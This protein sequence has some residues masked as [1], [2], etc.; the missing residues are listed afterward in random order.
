MSTYS[1]PFTVF[2]PTF[3]VPTLSP[4]LMTFLFSLCLQTCFPLLLLLR[5]TVVPFPPSPFSGIATMVGI[6]NPVPKVQGVERKKN[7]YEAGF[8]SSFRLLLGEG[9]YRVVCRRP[10]GAGVIALSGSRNASWQPERE[11]LRDGEAAC[12]GLPNFKIFIE[13]VIE[14]FPW[15]LSC[16]Y[17]A[18]FGNARQQAF[19]PER[20]THHRNRHLSDTAAAKNTAPGESLNYLMNPNMETWLSVRL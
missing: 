4:S 19:K 10:H 17:F 8:Q 20:Q 11:P 6:F 5:S 18:L 16:F 13:T 15:F 2:V 3:K 1:L 7:L 9:G 12:S 14:K